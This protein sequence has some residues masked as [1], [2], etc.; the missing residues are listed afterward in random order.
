MTASPIH[1]DSYKSSFSDGANRDTK[2]AA[3]LAVALDVRKFEIELYWKR[4]SY[5]WVF[6]GAALA[7]H[8]AALTNKDLV[9]RA[10][11]MLL[12][13]CVGLVFAFAWY[14]VNRASKF[15]QSNWEAHVDL[16]EDEVNG[17][18]YKTV[19]SDQTPWWKLHGAYQ[20][21][22]SKINQLLSLYVVLVFLLL[23][24]NT[25]LSYYRFSYQ[26]EVLP[27]FCLLLAGIATVLLVVFG[28]TGA[29][30]RKVSR[31][32]RRTAILNGNTND[33]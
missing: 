25:V 7:A 24:A 20:F 23:V 16:L 31:R 27:T 14:L 6:T 30:D 8:L 26:L 17:P 29:D 2:G 12:T 3:A 32:R 9:S 15:W 1:G 4:A 11:A 18:L 5:F 28:R 33:G 19:L 22:V 10:Q 13:S 21:S